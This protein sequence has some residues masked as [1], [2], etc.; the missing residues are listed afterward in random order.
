MKKIG[1]IFICLLIVNFVYAQDN[2][3]ISNQVIKLSAPLQQLGDN[4][5]R[6][7]LASAIAGLPE[8]NYEKFV[9]DNAGIGIAVA[10]SL[11]KP[12][13]MYTRSEFM[14]YGRIYFG[15]RKASG[16]YI[17]ANMAVV[18]QREYYTS[19]IWDINGNTTTKLIDNKSVCFG[20]GGA[21]GAKLLTR[22]GFVG[23]I[24]LGGGRVFGNAIVEGYPRIGFSIG[25]RF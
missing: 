21:V 11:E 22:N 5:I 15:E 16:F 13:N 19:Y 12:E 14:P 25:K 20:M 4:E 3:G 6:F 1:V 10:V 7:N 17:E 24:Y 8:F 18:G 23:E 9:S 2:Q